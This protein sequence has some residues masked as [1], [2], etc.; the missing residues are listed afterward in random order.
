MVLDRATGEGVSAMQANILGAAKDLF[1][2][3]GF[4]NVSMRAIASKIGYSPGAIYRY[5]ENKREIL[6]VLRHEAFGQFIEQQ[7]NLVSVKD[8]LDRVRQT[9]EYYLQ[10][11]LDEP[12]LFELMFNM[13]PSSVSLGGKWAD[14]PKEAFELF[15][16]NV[17]ECVS[18][19]CFGEAD[20]DTIVFSLWSTMHGL[21][22]LVVN[23]RL[24]GLADGMD[25]ETL[26]D[27]VVT[28]A[29]RSS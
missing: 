14:R 6:S 12:D 10:F 1:F 11:A 4:E 22:T 16:V 20:V 21:A 19:K 2:K 15:R 27:K 9:A 17:V 24:E 8:P 3:K 5:F 13:G 28:F 18:C 25:V 26:V 23:K 29:L 7:R